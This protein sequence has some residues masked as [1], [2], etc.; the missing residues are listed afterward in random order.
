MAL[1]DYLIDAIMRFNGK[2]RHKEHLSCNLKLPPNALSKIRCFNAKVHPTAAIVKEK[3]KRYHEL[4]DFLA[5][6]DSMFLVLYPEAREQFLVF[7][8]SEY[9]DQMLRVDYGE[10]RLNNR[11]PEH[12][13]SDSEPDED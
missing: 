11:P 12:V 9:L 8:A 4:I 10:A 7:Q 13:F 6:D 3:I 1:P 5:D 2:K